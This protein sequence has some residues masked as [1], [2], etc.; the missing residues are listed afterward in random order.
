MAA[1]YGV[2]YKTCA[3]LHLARESSKCHRCDRIAGTLLVSAACA[4][5]A[6]ESCNTPAYAGRKMTPPYEQLK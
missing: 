5:S 2:E 3:S 4:F 6:V 1:F